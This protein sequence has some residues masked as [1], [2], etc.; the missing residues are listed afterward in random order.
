MCAQRDV[1]KIVHCGII[2]NE[3]KWKQLNCLSPGKWRNKI[4]YIHIIKSFIA[5]RM[6]EPNYIQQEYSS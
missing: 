5:I 3:I 1:Q 4:M 6:N 2:C